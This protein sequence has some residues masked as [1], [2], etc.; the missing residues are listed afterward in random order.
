MQVLVDEST[1][2]TEPEVLVPLVMGA[3]QLVL[4]GDHC[5]LGPVI[6]NRKVASAMH[7]AALPAPCLPSA[8]MFLSDQDQFSRRSGPTCI[9]ASVGWHAPCFLL[10]QCR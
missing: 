5:Q 7:A 2:A 10:L 4:V 3:K 1:Q 9:D 8:Y 6:M